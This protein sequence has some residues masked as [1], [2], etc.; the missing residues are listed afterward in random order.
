MTENFSF[1]L[2][3][4]LLLRPKFVKKIV[5][6]IKKIKLQAFVDKMAIATLK[7]FEPRRVGLK[8]DYLSF[9]D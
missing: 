2:L 5:A 1:L 9:C 6:A 3:V 4:I 8:G 7:L